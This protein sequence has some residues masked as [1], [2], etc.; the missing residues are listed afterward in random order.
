MNSIDSA[1]FEAEHRDRFRGSQ[2]ITSLPIYPIKFDASFATLRQNLLAQGTQFLELT[3]TPYAHKLLVGKT[4]DE[5]V[6][7]VRNP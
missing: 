7:E 5:P 2:T 1:I 6:E 4:L 3:K